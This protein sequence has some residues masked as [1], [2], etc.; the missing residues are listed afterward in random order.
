MSTERGGGNSKKD[1][2]EIL[3]ALLPPPRAAGTEEKYTS[4]Y[5]EYVVR[6]FRPDGVFYLVTTTGWIF[7]LHYYTR[8]FPDPRFLLFVLQNIAGYKNAVECLLQ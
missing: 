3:T 5:G 6:S 8:F 4:A 1:T 7:E 2:R